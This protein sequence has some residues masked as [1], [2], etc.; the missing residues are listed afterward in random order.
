M[1]HV[2]HQRCLR[3]GD[4]RDA[5]GGRGVGEPLG[6]EEDAGNRVVYRRA[7]GLAAHTLRGPLFHE[8]SLT[9][10]GHPSDVD[11]EAPGER[12]VAERSD[13]EA[14]GSHQLWKLSGDSEAT[15]AVD[16]QEPKMVV[17]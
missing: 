17:V 11:P 10:V 13:L 5:R 4:R 15:V 12:E 16:L 3:A 7:R 14:A 9:G 6:F 8:F 1:V 2:R